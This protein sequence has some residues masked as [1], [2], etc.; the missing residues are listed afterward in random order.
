LIGA[1]EAEYGQLLDAA[2]EIDVIRQRLQER[3]GES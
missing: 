2:A 3:H 1:A